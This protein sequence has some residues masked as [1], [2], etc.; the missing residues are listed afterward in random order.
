MAKPIILKYSLLNF[1]D[2]ID[3]EFGFLKT[4]FKMVEHSS[5]HT[6]HVSTPS[7]PFGLAESVFSTA[8]IIAFASPNAK[9]TISHD[10][11]GAVEVAIAQLIPPFRSVTVE[12]L[13]RGADDKD[14]T[15]YGETYDATRETAAG[16]LHRLATELRKYAPDWLKPAENLDRSAS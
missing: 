13:A 9:V 10:P 8:P 5:T 7:S 12:D 14:A 1:L 2:D 4:D 3:R 15:V 6:A 11:R 16:P